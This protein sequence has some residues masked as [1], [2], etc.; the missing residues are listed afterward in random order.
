M[1]SPEFTD[2]GKYVGPSQSYVELRQKVIA[3]TK[4]MDKISPCK[5]GMGYCCHAHVGVSL[6]ESQE[7]VGAARDG[8]IPE[9]VI[10]RVAENLAQENNNMCPF[11][12]K[13]RNCMIYEYRPLECV[14]YGR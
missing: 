6:E 13:T 7:I 4:Q 5:R 9:E 14:N 8:K 1:S 10:N 12:G 2:I 11:L 3:D